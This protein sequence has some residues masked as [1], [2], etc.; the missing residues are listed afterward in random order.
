MHSWAFTN[1]SGVSNKLKVGRGTRLII[2]NLVTS[3]KKG[4][5]EVIYFK[6]NENPKD[7]MGGGG[8]YS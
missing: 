5:G 2:R 4:G 6:N 8:V 1:P 3:G 7:G